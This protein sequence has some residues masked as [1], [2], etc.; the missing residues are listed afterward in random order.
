M[1][2]NLDN[3]PTL[4][5]EETNTLAQQVQR[6]MR[7]LTDLG[8]TGKNHERIKK[9]Q[10]LKLNKRQ[11][12][13]LRNGIKS[14]EKMI[15]HNQKLVIHW[16]SRIK[17]VKLDQDDL[18]SIG[19][20]G[21][22]D[23][24][25]RYDPDKG[26]KFSTYAYLWVRSE[27]AK[28]RSRADADLSVSLDQTR[29]LYKIN[30][31]KQTFRA[32]HQRSPKM[33]EISEYCKLSEQSI[34]N[35]IKHHYSGGSLQADGENS[36]HWKAEDLLVGDGDPIYNLID[37][38]GLTANKLLIEDMLDM[39]PADIKLMFEDYYLREIPPKKIAV[40][41]GISV[42]KLKN[43]LN[44]HIHYLNLKFAPEANPY[45]G[46]LIVDTLL[47]EGHT[48]LL[49]WLYLNYESFVN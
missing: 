9:A 10:Q 40:D 16:S 35:T 39:L 24:V 3:Y 33:T 38:E 23:A 43:L 14:R 18:V 26:Y 29:R 48:K 49:F 7:L 45:V 4:S 5:Q 27:M 22:I 25:E 15:L 31:A 37:R 32:E 47:L 21:L 41:L 12:I 19:T 2:L 42:Q 30:K 34:R 8:L 44:E 17:S 11:S 20:F 6:M 36:D 28:K 13:I 1:S 46:S